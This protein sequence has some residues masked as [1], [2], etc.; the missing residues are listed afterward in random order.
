MREEL[1]PAPPAPEP[2]IALPPASFATLTPRTL[3]SAITVEAALYALLF[4][5]ALLMRLIELGERPLATHEAASALAAWQF[6][7]G[8]A[9]GSMSSPFLMSASLLLFMLAGATDTAARFAPA[10]IG[11]T[12]VLLP[13][14]VRREIGRTSALLSALIL[15][16]STSLVWFARDLNGVEISA[17]AGTAGLFWFWHYVR[18]NHARDLYL[19]AGAAALALTA[20]AAGF[21]I[22]FAGLIGALLLGGRSSRIKSAEAADEEESSNGSGAEEAGRG[23]VVWRNALVLFAAVYLI[24]ATAF[25]INREGLGASF[26]LFGN[27]L[28]MFQTF[29]PFTEPLN[30]LLIYEP[31]V[32]VFGFAGLLLVPSLGRDELRTRG[33]LVL[34]AV[35]TVVG[36]IVYSL[37]GVKF[38]GDMVVLV[39]PL[40]LLAGWF[41]G[42]LLERG[43]EELERQGG[44][45]V[46]VWGELPILVMAIAF[47]AFIYLNLASLLDHNTLFP[48]LEAFRQ[49]LAAVISPAAPTALEPAVMSLVFF[50][51]V[52][53]VLLVL[54]SLGSIG[55]A[56]T[57]NLAAVVVA[58]LLA[59]SGV[60]ATWLANYSSADTV[61]E[62]IAGDQTSLQARDFLHD[63]EWESEWRAGDPHVIATRADPALGPVVRWYLR[64]FP[65]MQWISQPQ[66][67]VPAPAAGTNQAQT[68]L[69]PQAFVTTADAHAPT[70]NW[71][72]ELYR[73]QLDWQ[74]TET[75]R[76]Q[77]FQWL[78]FRTGGVEAWQSVKLWVPKPE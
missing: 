12:V 27:W 68:D 73:V 46:A 22:L 57:A 16:L 5:A 59:L 74:L 44:S 1:V 4:L 9:P 35:L 30:L 38:A 71:V 2:A 65:N 55:G 42:N 49:L 6:S 36:L 52:I 43:F 13:A 61:H 58:L 54:L 78:L 25:L 63:L 29:G 50:S 8:T 20:S 19:A 45:R 41:I 64:A 23:R 75:S 3:V 40:A 67:N 11:S 77:L 76:T 18:E 70:G 28:A 14:L 51:L 69:V 10:L 37:A 47:P 32:L 26:N 34:C 48:I 39:I 33:S 15:L 17:V 24:L 56:R 62:L 7:Q 53:V 31:L 21:T 66:A 60:R 72:S